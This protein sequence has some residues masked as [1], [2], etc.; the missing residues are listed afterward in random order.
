MS[1]TSRFKYM[2]G[3]SIVIMAIGLVVALIAGG[4]N[5]G[6]DFG[7]GTLM[8]IELHQLD[9]DMDVVNAALAENN[10]SD[11]Q[12]V[13]SGITTSAQTMV[14]IRLKNLDDDEMESAQ[15]MGILEA[16]QRTYPDAEIDTVERVDGVASAGLIKNA[17]LSILIASVLIMLY[18]WV[19]FELLSGV[20]AIVALL[21]DVAIM[22]AITSILRIQVNSSFIAAILTIVGYSINNTIVV[23]DRIRENR[24][25]SVNADKITEEIVNKS[26]KGT[27]T[28]S[29]NTSITTLLTITMVYFLGV[30]SIQEFTLPIIVGLLAGTYSSVFLAGPMWGKWYLSRLKKAKD[31]SANIKS[32]K[33]KGAAGNS[34]S[35]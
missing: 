25:S 19:R 4:L 16:V 11:A 12:A 13:R 21:H 35:K 24:K 8:N 34:A 14:S 26:I 6:V 28:R 31:A 2:A 27:L 18:V 29:I 9:F 22:L 5:L 10:A 20:V 17:I 1:F 33:K 7:A 15:R 32:K 23:F 30:Q 3:V